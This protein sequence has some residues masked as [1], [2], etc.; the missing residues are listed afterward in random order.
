VRAEQD[1]AVAVAPL[2]IGEIPTPLLIE[3]DDGI[4]PAAPIEIRPLVAHAQVHLDDATGDG[5]EIDDSGK[6]IEMPSNPEA[7][8]IFDFRFVR[9]VDNPVIECAVRR[10][11]AGDVA[12]PTRFP[13]HDRNVRA[14]V[15]PF[16]QRLNATAILS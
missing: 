2:D 9:G 15:P 1:D 7:T 8:T 14:Q 12:P 5:F 16:E 10:R 13:G 6:A 3:P 11:R 4:G